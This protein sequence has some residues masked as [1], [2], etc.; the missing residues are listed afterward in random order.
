M[1]RHGGGSPSPLKP[2]L[3]TNIVIGLEGDQAR[4][5]SN[6]LMVRESAAGPLLAIAGTYEDLVVRTPAGWR[7]QH[8]EILN[9]IA[10]DL[11]L[12]R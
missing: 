9:D 5:K 8:R 4:V 11:G 12:K 6:F 3:A 2:G 10:G 1:G 7:F